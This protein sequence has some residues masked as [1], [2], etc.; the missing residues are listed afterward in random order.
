[1]SAGRPHFRLHGRSSTPLPPVLLKRSGAVNRPE[2]RTSPWEVSDG[3][4]RLLWDGMWRLAYNGLVL[5]R[6][7]TSRR[8]QKG[9][10]GRALYL[11]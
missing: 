3:L 6:T 4:R 2:R 5:I 7:Y 1:M 9:T 10:L 8:D 11:G